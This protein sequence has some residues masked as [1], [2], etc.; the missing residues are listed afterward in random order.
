MRILFKD[1]FDFAAI[2]QLTGGSLGASLPRSHVNQQ[3]IR[4]IV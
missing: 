4:E 1:V 2:L 3:R